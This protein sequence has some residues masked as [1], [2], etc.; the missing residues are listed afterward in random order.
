MNEKEDDIK[1]LT[2]ESLRTEKKRAGCVSNGGGKSGGGES[3]GGKSGGGK[4]G[5]GK[6]TVIKSPPNEPK[7]TKKLEP[8][9]GEV[10]EECGEAHG[11]CPEPGEDSYCEKESLHSGKHK[12]KSC[13]RLF[14][15]E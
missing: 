11:N 6:G 8:P 1:V 14:E 9:E 3:G 15:T 4:S 12:C 13:E 2:I 10:P 7:S 5:G